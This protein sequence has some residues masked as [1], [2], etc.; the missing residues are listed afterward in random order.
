MAGTLDTS[1]STSK[2]SHKYQPAAALL[3]ITA[4]H[5]PEIFFDITEQ[6]H[7]FRVLN[8]LPAPPAVPTAPEASPALAQLQQ[9]RRIQELPDVVVSDDLD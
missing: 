5:Y 1:R 3:F 8:A 9:H 7:A 2:Y 4:C 6:L